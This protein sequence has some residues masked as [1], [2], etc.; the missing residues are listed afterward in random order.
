VLDQETPAQ[1]LQRRRERSRTS[2]RGAP[3][4]FV[5]NRVGTDGLVSADPGRRGAQ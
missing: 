3:Q 2:S 5:R 1:L 4:T